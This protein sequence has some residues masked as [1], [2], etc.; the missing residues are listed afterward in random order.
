MQV[1]SSMRVESCSKYPTCS[2]RNSANCASLKV[3]ISRSPH[4]M[5]PEGGGAMP[6]MW[7][8]RLVFP[9]PLR[10]DSAQNIPEVTSRLKSLM[11][12]IGASDRFTPGYVISKSFTRNGSGFIVDLRLN[13]AFC[14]VWSQRYVRLQ[15][16]F[17]R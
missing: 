6:L 16:V 9:D 2:G 17:P 8:R 12:V 1:S 7:V 13:G 3:A 5:A 14:L 4:Q 10:P 11:I 15:P